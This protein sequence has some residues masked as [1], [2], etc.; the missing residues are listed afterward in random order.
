MSGQA[1]PGEIALIGSYAVDRPGPCFLPGHR[2]LPPTAPAP[3]SDPES[4][5][6]VPPPWPQSP[7]LAGIQ[8]GGDLLSCL[9]LFCK[10]FYGSEMPFYCLKI[11]SP[12]C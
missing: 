7:F 11:S 6:K 10:P 8:Q 2:E 3:G 9:Q 1:W 12:H 5:R 4:S